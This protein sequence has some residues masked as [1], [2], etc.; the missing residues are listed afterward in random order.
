MNRAAR[1]GGGALRGD[2]T[3]TETPTP[4]GQVGG[5][6]PATC[7][8]L[9]ADALA[10]LVES[11]YD[12]GRVVTCQFF[13]Y[14]LSHT[15]LVRT[16]VEK[17]MLR[18]YRAGWRTPSDILYE[19]DALRHLG[20]KGVPVSSPVQRRDGSLVRAL[21]AMEGTRQAVLF[22]FAPGREAYRDE[23]YPRRFGRA[24][25]ELYNAMDD[26]ASPHQRFPLDFG[27]LLEQPL[28]AIRPFLAHRQDDW[29]YF[30]QLGE[31]LRARAEALPLTDLEAG[32][33]H[34]DFHGGNAHLDGETITHFDFDCCGP[35]W[36]AYDIAVYRWN[37]S[38]IKKRA[39]PRWTEFLDGYTAVR[40]LRELDLVATAIF[41]PIRHLWWLG[42]Q[43][44]NADDWGIGRR[45]DRFFDRA[46]TYLKT[47]ERRHLKEGR[48]RRR[49]SA[50]A[51]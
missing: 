31:K 4:N 1:A 11:E 18:V 44:G 35:G 30:Q 39:A 14:G 32:F 49:G 22:T 13:M 48:R 3:I 41:V 42:L 36:R 10:R 12:L 40:P 45:D 47:W 19:L 17:Y 7:S 34:G 15:Y 33:C 23:E 21:A 50:A 9:A 26:F 2:G 46:L 51:T 25:A 37:A 28:A 8:I 20:H 27:H 6:F 38:S 24:V 29:S 5:R 16:E 43:C